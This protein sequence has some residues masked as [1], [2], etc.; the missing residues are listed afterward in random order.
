MSIRA[1]E[2]GTTVNIQISS[3]FKFK[4]KKLRKPNKK[5]LSNGRVVKT[6][7]LPFELYCRQNFGRRK[8]KVKKINIFSLMAGPF[9]PHHRHFHCAGHRTATNF[10]FVR[11]LSLI[12]ITLY[13][14]TS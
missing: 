4:V 14:V 11:Q 10:H 13:K 12:E 3:P 8:T 2:E 5:N 7:T 1:V 6:L 9:P